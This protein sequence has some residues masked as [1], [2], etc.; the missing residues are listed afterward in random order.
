V[1]TQYQTIRCGLDARG[2]AR[3]ELD[4]ADVFNAFDEAMIAELTACF[5]ALS[6]DHGV[7]AVVLAAPGKLFCAGADLNWMRRASANAPDEN[8]AD[9]ERF[10]T[11]M[12]AIYRCTKPVVARVQGSAFGGGVGLACACD[13]VVASMQARFSVSE[14][15]FGILPAV[16]GPYLIEAVGVRAARALA[17]TTELIGA[18]EAHRIGLVQHVVEFDELDAK[19]ESVIAQLV[20]NGPTAQSEIKQLFSAL[21]GRGITTDTSAL[22]A[23]TIARV[24]S[25]EEAR[26]GFAAFFDKRAASWSR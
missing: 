18:V 26:E 20:A 3:V 10:A 6:A 11:M 4:R 5:T 16:I 7:R 8:R 12:E 21:A 1:N 25:N 13:I 15:R 2:V 17:L 9:A 23:T 24:R 22:T 19:V 14:A